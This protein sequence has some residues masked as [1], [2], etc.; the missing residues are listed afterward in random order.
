MQY[1]EKLLARFKDQIKTNK[2]LIGVAAGSGLT[3]KYAEQGGADLILAL[4]LGR[5]K[6]IFLYDN[7]HTNVEIRKL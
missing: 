3:S 2:H 4:S 6:I 5:L 7:K 1:K